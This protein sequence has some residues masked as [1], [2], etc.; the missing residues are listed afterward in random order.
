M[1]GLQCWGSENGLAG[2][3]YGP[4]FVGIKVIITVIAEH[5]T[6]YSELFKGKTKN[7]R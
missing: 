2:D 3:P 4:F 6:V 5:K 7:T 1:L